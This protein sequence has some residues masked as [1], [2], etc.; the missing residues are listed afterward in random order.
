MAE[1]SH[2]RVHWLHSSPDDPIDLWSELNIDREEV[3]KVEIWANGRVG[4]P[5]TQ[6]KSEE[7]GSARSRLLR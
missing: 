6:E 5:L 4:L 7:P 3:P 1:H 2:I